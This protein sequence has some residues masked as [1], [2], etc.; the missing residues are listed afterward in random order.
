[1]IPFDTPPTGAIPADRAA[2][3]DCRLICAFKESPCTSSGPMRRKMSRTEAQTAE[4][5]GKDSFNRMRPQP[6][7]ATSVFRRRGHRRQPARDSTTRKRP[8]AGLLRPPRGCPF[9]PIARERSQ[10]RYPGQLRL[11]WQP[12]RS[13]PLPS[14]ISSKALYYRL[15]LIYFARSL[16]RVN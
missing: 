7:V 16:R 5:E 15:R 3:T 4:E 13:L 6:Q 12:C 8:A 11:R 10:A 2:Q 14:S 9:G 1:M